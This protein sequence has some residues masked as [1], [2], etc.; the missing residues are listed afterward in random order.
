MAFRL[1]AK[2]ILTSMRHKC[3]EGTL[4]GVKP[5]R[6]YRCCKYIYEITLIFVRLYHSRGRNCTT[7]M[8]ILKSLSFMFRC[9]YESLSGCIFYLFFHWN[10]SP[11]WALQSVVCF[12][13]SNNVL[14]FFLSVTNSLNLF[15]SSTWRSLSTSLHS[16]LGRPLHFVISLSCIKSFLGILSSSI[17]SR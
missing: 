3:K 6:W 14:P 4:F 13:L 7:G 11:F 12:G 5:W 16:Y 2:P 1:T 15:T 17:L 8:F 9:S 10:Y